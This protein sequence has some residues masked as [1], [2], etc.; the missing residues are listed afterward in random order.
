MSKI[1]YKYN[2]KTLS[3]EKAETSWRK[4]IVAAVSF[5]ATASVIGVVA[6]IIAFKYFDSPKEKQMRREMAKMERQ[7]EILNLRTKNLEKVLEDLEQRDD[8]I[9]RVLFEAE[10]IPDEIRKA[11]FGG[12]ERYKSLE[13]F[14]NSDLMISV[15]Q[16]LDRISK[17]MYIQSKSYDEVIKLAKG[18]TELLAAIPA[19]MPISNSDL[20][21]APSGFGWR[22]HPIYKTQEFHP[23]MD[24]AAPEGTEIYATG[25][26]VVLAA[27]DKSQGYGNRVIINHGF[28]YQTLYGHMTKFAVKEGQKVKRGQIIGYVGSTGLSTAPHVHYEVTKNNERMNPINYYYSDLTPE[29]YQ[30]LIE[31]SSQPSQAFD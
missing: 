7:Y 1:R 5:L 14:D 20:R 8:N 2:T 29:Q 26:G 11:G 4:R 16:N 19:I 31:L 21:H 23:G 22:T 6:V 13:G 27:D 30:K 17:Q 12:A 10:P 25:D 9:Y 3:Y 18:K 28:G 15:T 24:F